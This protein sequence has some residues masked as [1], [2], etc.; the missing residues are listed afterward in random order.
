MKTKIIQIFPVWEI[1]EV[2]KFQ[3]KSEYQFNCA[4]Q[5][6][7]HLMHQ[8]IKHKHKHQVTKTLQYN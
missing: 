8:L 6:I 3:Q 2:T 4:G 5:N 1:G 7:S